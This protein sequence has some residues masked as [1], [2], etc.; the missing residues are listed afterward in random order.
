MATLGWLALALFDRNPV[1]G[2]RGN[3]GAS[4]ERANHRYRYGCVLRSWRLDLNTRSLHVVSAADSV[5]SF[6]CG[7]KLLVVLGKLA[8]TT[9]GK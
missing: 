9:A 4:R 7:N 3:S 1:S 6:V 5:I 8:Q 2:R